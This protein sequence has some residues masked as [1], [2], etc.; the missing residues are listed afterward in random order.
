MLKSIIE[1][2]FFIV[3]RPLSLD[4]IARFTREKRETVA[5]IIRE[6][7]SEYNLKDGGIKIIENGNNV[8]MVTNPRHYEWIK[9]FSQEEFSGEI[10][11]ASLETLAIIAYRGPVLREE[12]E[13]IRG[14][15]C[16]IILR[17]LMIKGL[18]EERKENERIFY[19]LSLDFIRQLGIQQLSELPN[20][21]YLHNLPLSDLNN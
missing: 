8:Q 7:I 13:Q 2:L 18:I 19:H 17:H 20:Y 6:M 15:N 1:S 10:T 3:D 5:S 12:I 4:E 9:R 21:E 16:A 14:V 11:P